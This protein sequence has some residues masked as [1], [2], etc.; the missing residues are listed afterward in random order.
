VKT[1]DWLRPPAIDDPSNVDC[2]SNRD[3]D[4]QDDPE[5]PRFRRERRLILGWA[6]WS[7]PAFEG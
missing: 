1:S 2:F 7:R 4:L 5:M 3:G 6:S